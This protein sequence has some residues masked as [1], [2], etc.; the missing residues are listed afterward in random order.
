MQI[1][2]VD[3]MCKS[4]SNRSDPFVFFSENVL[5]CD[6]VVVLQLK[7]LAAIFLAI[8]CICYIP[9]GIGFCIGSI[10]GKGFGIGKGIGIF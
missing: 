6:L 1:I 10:Y 4:F 5:Y 3:E 2:L 9:I 7:A 8:N